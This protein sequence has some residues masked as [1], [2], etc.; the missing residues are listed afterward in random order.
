M[1]A[2]TTPSSNPPRATPAI[3]LALVLL[4]GLAVGGAVVL[5]QGR[6]AP[7]TSIPEEVL[8]A[9]GDSPVPTSRADARPLP[10]HSGPGWEV[11][12]T[13]QK[14]ALYPLAERWAYLSEVQKHHWLTIAQTFASRPAAE[15]QRLHQ[16]MTAW[17]SLS[18]QQRSQ[19]RLNFAVSRGLAPHDLLAEWETYQA[20]S[21]MEKQRLAAKAAKPKGAAT[22]LK[23]VHSKRLTH[24]PAA[25]DAQ[26]TAANPPKIVLPSTTAIRPM[27]VPEPVALPP[28]PSVSADERQVPPIPD[29]LDETPPQSDPLPPVYI[30]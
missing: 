14:L 1:P 16:R 15:Q 19:A 29:P 10:Q 23:P 30:N 20:L 25:S 8:S 26:A 17:A 2:S 6:T 27:P 18:T 28:S 11:M 24:V 9:G 4:A 5:N 3:V 13:P 21:E 7:G 22:A 12:T